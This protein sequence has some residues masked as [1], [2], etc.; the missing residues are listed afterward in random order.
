MSIADQCPTLFNAL[1]TLSGAQ[2]KARVNKTAPVPGTTKAAL[3]EKLLVTLLHRGKTDLADLIDDQTLVVAAREALSA[4]RAAVDREFAIFAGYAARK[5]ADYCPAV[6]AAPAADPISKVCPTLFGAITKAKNDQLTVQANKTAPVRGTDKTALAEKALVTMLHRNHTDLADLI[7]KSSLPNNVKTA[8]AENRA[9]CEAEY[10]AFWQY[11]HAAYPDYVGK[12]FAKGAALTPAPAKP[13][14]ASRAQ[15]DPARKKLNFEEPAPAS[16]PRQRKPV[17]PPVTP[18]VAQTTKAQTT[19][20]KTKA[21]EGG[22]G[23]VVLLSGLAII[24]VAAY[25]LLL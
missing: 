3:T 4:D 23:F 9:I 14:A 17:D 11:A 13:Q 1:S 25:Y 8:L 18:S 7:D 21:A 12:P 24:A 10:F 6:V 16:K 2:L 19:K 22:N 5:Y 15:L 20:T